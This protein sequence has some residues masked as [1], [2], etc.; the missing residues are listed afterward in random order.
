MNTIFKEKKKENNKILDIK[1]CENL[2]ETIKLIPIYFK[3]VF[4]KIFY[5]REF[6]KKFLILELDLDNSLEKQ[7][8]FYGKSLIY[9]R[10]A[11]Y[12]VKTSIIISID[13][14]K[15]PFTFTKIDHKNKEN[16][17]LYELVLYNAKK[18][19][20][21]IRQK[22]YFKRV[23]KNIIY[24]RNLYNRG[25]ILDKKSL[26]LV[27]LTSSTF[28]ELYEILIKVFNEEETSNIIKELHHLSTNIHVIKK[29]KKFQKSKNINKLLAKQ[30]I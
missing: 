12:V 21:N 14:C 29:W 17:K 25:V 13:G 3:P 27:I 16:N 18:N 4:N 23:K 30:N 24:Y 15:I 1:Y 10:Y 22:E 20:S 9:N 19:K 2:D 6:L 11:P 28:K 5:K 7:N 26:L 8:T